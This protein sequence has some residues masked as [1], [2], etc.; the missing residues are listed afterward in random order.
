MTTSGLPQGDDPG[1]EQ[2]A[3]WEE[4]PGDG[5]PEDEAVVAAGVG[6]G[7]SRGLT[8]TITSTARTPGPAGL[9]LADVPNR[10]MALVIDII[11][12]SLVGFALAWL[13]GG[14]VSEPGAI[15]AP[16]GELD[17]LAFLVV[18]VLQLGI[19]LAYF[20]GLWTYAGV[21]VGMRLLGL[22]IGDERDGSPLILRHSLVRWLIVGI[23][24][25]LTSLVVYVPSAVGLILAVVGMA[26]LL[27]LLYTIAQSPSKQGF[28]DRYAHTILVRARRRAH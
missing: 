19:S 26:W 23:P 12:L 25:L 15:D 5:V 4:T 7:S 2:E 10:I 16:G 18:L 6:A 14:L 27:F 21:T 22:R 24:A 17:L 28:H 20:A 3:I 11:V 13:F 9:Y 1:P 8:R